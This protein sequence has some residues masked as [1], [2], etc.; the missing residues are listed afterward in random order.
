MCNIAGYI[1]PRPAAPILC[2]M[3]KRQSGFGGGYYSGIAVL[4]DRGLRGVKLRGDMDLLTSTTNARLHPGRVGILHS[5]SRSG[6]DGRWAHPFFSNDGRLAYVANGSAGAFRGLPNADEA[7]CALEAKGVRFT[8]AAPG[9][10][11]Y[12]PHLADGRCVHVSE[13]M[14]HLTRTTMK[15][16]G[17][18]LADALE[19][20]FLQCPAEIVA[21]AVCEEEP[22]SISF[23]RVNMPMFVGR[24][25]DEV[26]LA[27]TA[28]AFPADRDYISVTAIPEGSYGTVSL[29]GTVIRRFRTALPV[30]PLTAARA[31]R[32]RE[33]ILAA[34]RASDGPLTT[35]DMQKA[36]APCWDEPDTLSQRNFAVYTIV[37][38]L[39]KEGAVTIREVAEYWDPGDGTPVLRRGRNVI[40]LNER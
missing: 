25:E 11:S 21:L 39:V 40:F 30:S 7:T 37:Q 27:S 26:F 32:I 36:S 14:A 5:R 20:A 18:S 33:A 23:A 22:D 12:Y 35:Q 38:E 29:R 1:G 3:M 16:R 13:T 31:G 8:S 15:E 19:A 24:T 9:K 2:E 6:G 4:G 34:L 10:I 28:L 17:C